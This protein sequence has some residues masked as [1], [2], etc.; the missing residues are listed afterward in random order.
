MSILILK[1]VLRNMEIKWRKL[2][3][4]CSVTRRALFYEKV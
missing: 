4:L 3:R 2:N 1:G